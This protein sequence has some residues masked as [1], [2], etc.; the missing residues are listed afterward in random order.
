MANNRIAKICENS[1]FVV[2]HEVADSTG[3]F[4]TRKRSPA[5][6]GPKCGTDLFTNRNQH[7]HGCGFDGIDRRAAPRSAWLK[8]ELAKVIIAGA[9]VSASTAGIGLVDK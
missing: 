5:A 6:N 2:S 1:V 7:A 8:T 3:N 9:R 4:F